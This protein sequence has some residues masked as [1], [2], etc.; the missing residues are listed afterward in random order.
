MQKSKKIEIDEI[1][2]SIGMRTAILVDGA[3]FLNTHF[4]LFIIFLF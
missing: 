1:E 3:L 2:K 4:R